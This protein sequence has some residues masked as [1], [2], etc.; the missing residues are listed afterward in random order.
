MRKQFAGKRDF[1]RIAVRVVALA[2]A[3]WLNV[4]RENYLASFWSLK[5]PPIPD[6][7]LKGSQL[8]ELKL[9][10]ISLLEPL[11]NSFGFQPTVTFQQIPHFWPHCRKR[12]RS[13]A[14]LSLFLRFHPPSSLQVISRRAHRH[15]SFGGRSFQSV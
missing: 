13:C 14:V 10:R 11:H 15:A 8:P 7:T 12:V 4:L 5:N 6:S 9:S 3:P 1:E 2:L